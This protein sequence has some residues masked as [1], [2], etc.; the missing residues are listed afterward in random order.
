MNREKFLTGLKEQKL[1]TSFT[2]KQVDSITAILDEVERQK[3]TAPRQ[4]AYIFAT[5]YWEAHNPRKPEERLTPM[6]GS[7]QLKQ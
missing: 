1:F 6:P 4:V 2:Q 7:G 3:V 5:A